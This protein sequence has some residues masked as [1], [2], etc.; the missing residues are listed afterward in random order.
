MK[1]DD[2][3]E[4]IRQ[5]SRSMVRELGFMQSD[6]VE[7]GI[8]HTQCHAL[9]ETAKHGVLA[10]GDLAE[11]LRIN[12]S[13]ASRL[14]AQLQKRRLIRSVP[15]S[16]DARRKDVTLTPSGQKT[17]DAINQRAAQQVASALATLTPEQRRTI[18]EGIDLYARALRRANNSRD[19]QIRPIQRKDNPYVRAILRRVME[20]FGANNKGF[21]YFD[22]EVDDMYGSYTADGCAYLVATRKERVI[23]GGGIG[24]LVGGDTGTCELKKMY[25]YPEARGLGLGYRILEQLL[26]KAREFGYAK[27]YLETMAAMHDA[28]R[29]YRKFGFQELDH[30]LGETGH[31]GCNRWFLLELLQAR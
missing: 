1:S 27:C 10:V 23:G 5:R 17:V 6:A 9:L 15:A 20:E 7:T 29:L 8:P 25:F 28:Q 13:S 14:L 11:L 19:I 31:T 18:A 4:V 16:D 22:S 30:P 2:I 24:P 21:A 12:K 3:V 26:T